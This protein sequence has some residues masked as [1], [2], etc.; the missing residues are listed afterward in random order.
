VATE[1]LKINCKAQSQ[2]RTNPQIKNNKKSHELGQTKPQTQHTYLKSSTPL[3]FFKG[4][5]IEEF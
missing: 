3:T 1:K 2:T 4:K 5:C